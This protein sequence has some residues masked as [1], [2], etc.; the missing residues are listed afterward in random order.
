MG[1]LAVNYHNFGK[2]TEAEKLGIQVLA[3]RNIILGAEHPG[4][5][6][7]SNISILGKIQRQKLEMQ[8]LHARSRIRGV[9]HQDTI[10]A[11]ANLA[12]TY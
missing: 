8:V 6:N 2:Y 1:N 7:G 3:A 5:A 9:E 11:M 4:T 12:A 10:S